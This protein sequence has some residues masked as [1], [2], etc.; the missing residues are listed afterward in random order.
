MVGCV[1]SDPP[2]LDVDHAAEFAATLAVVRAVVGGSGEL[3]TPTGYKF[4][5]VQSVARVRG[6]GECHD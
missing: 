5:P 2:W 4:F 6:N 3:S 1:G